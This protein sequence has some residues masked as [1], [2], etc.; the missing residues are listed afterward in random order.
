MVLVGRWCDGSEGRRFKIT[1]WYGNLVTTSADR[2][3]GEESKRMG[4]GMDKVVECVLMISSLFTYNCRS[5]HYQKP[6][7]QN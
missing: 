3:G 2:L 6:K 1:V 7:S 4:K 5:F